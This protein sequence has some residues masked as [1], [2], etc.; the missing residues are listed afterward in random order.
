MEPF[1]DLD[2]DERPD[3]PDGFEKGLPID[4]RVHGEHE[5][6]LQERPAG[7]TGHILLIC[8]TMLRQQD[9]F[10]M[11]NDKGVVDEEEHGKK[12]KDNDVFGQEADADGAEEAEDVQR[13]ADDGIGT[14]RNQSMDLVA[15]DVHKGPKTP[16]AAHADEKDPGHLEEYIPDTFPGKGI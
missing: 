6:L 12:G 1:D 7:N 15:G 4:G 5:G 9:M 11:R 3:E 13:M 16:E 10:F 8:P 2:R 14:F